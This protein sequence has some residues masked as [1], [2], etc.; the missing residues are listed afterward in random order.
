MENR[1]GRVARWTAFAGVSLVCALVTPRSARACGGL[2][3]DGP[4]ANPFAPLPVAQNGENVVFSIDKDPAGGATKMTAQIQILYT[5][6][7]AQFS[8]VVPVDAMPTLGVG[9]DQLFT[10]LLSATQPQFQALSDVDGTCLP[11]NYGGKGI[12]DAGIISTPTNSSG[13]AG[14]ATGGGPTGSVNV[15]FQGGV[16]PYDAAVI[17]STDPTALKT[18]LTTNGYVVD[19]SAS[20]IIDQYVKENKF[21][22]A[23][24][25]MNGMGTSSIQ[26][27]V[28]TFYAT[29]PC[30]PLRLTAIA[31]NPDMPVRVWVLADGRVVPKTFLEV[32][33]DEARI[34]WLNGGSNYSS[35][36][37]SLLSQA[38]D[39]AGGNAFITEYAGP[40]SIAAQLLWSP[41]RF[42]LT[43]L[44]AAQTPPAYVQ[45][46]INLGLASNSQVLPL[47]DMYIPM[48]ADLKAMGITDAQ[49]YANISSYYSQYAFPAFDLATLTTKISANII[50][51]LH[52][53][54]TMID[55]H[56]Y[57]TRMNTFISP[58]EMTKDA[59]FFASTGLGDVPLVHTAT[60]RTMCGQMKFMGCNA[61]VRL[62]LADGRKAWVRAG[63]TATTC[64]YR[65][66]DLSGLQ[67]L[68]AS[69]MAF[70]RDGL[71][72]GMEVV[73]NSAAIDKGLA[74][75]NN[76]Y[77]AEQNMFPTPTGA[78]G[79]TSASSGGGCSCEMGGRGAGGLGLGILALGVA[80]GSFAVRRRRSRR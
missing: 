69:A 56:A 71:G 29:E 70:Q 65:S 73:D 38:A 64:D 46:L 79:A 27:I 54:Q 37:N 80:A 12:F 53:A 25:L 26:P 45:A 6:D 58:P 10:S 43:A 62:E 32:Q 15:T 78:P 4:P 13:G 75:N 77:P 23:L 33:I 28:L 44:Q 52:A 39:E 60:F 20:A 76:A 48:P 61:P 24:K 50:E 59:F 47:L 68:P 36:S 5:G 40:A 57:M 42:D 51:P 35:I 30:I 31:A 14:G 21:F 19:D 7:A 63:S 41:T 66:Y 34:D 16:G 55:S 22:V 3:C 67:G 72:E 17:Q 11:D 9:T 18:W 1:V 49:F 2:F 8:W 74:A